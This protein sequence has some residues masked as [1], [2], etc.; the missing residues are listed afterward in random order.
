MDFLT[1]QATAALNGDNSALEYVAEESYKLAFAIGL[2][3]LRNV[4]D[5]EDI[6]QVVSERSCRLLREGKESAFRYNGDA[7]YKTWLHT[8]T[9]NQIRNVVRHQKRKDY[10]VSLDEE[11]ESGDSLLELLES[12]DKN[13]EQNLLAREITDKVLDACNQMPFTYLF[14]F[15][16]RDLDQLTYEEIAEARRITIGTVRSRIHRGRAFVKKYLEKQG[17]DLTA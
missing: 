16:L 9:W 5:A 4:Q 1:S 17:I 3:K 6:A 11:N 14:E 7:T 10:A 13:P 12:K 8:V 2:K 15:V